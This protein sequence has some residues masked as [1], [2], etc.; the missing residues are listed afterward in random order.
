MGVE[1]T[2]K[3]RKITPLELQ[4]KVKEG[5]LWIIY[6][7][8]IIDVT[9]WSLYHPGGLLPLK[10]AA[11]LDATAQIRVFHPDY[12]LDKKLGSFIIGELSVDGGDELV[13]DSGIVDPKFISQAQRQII[14]SKYMSLQDEIEKEGLEITN[15]IFYF[16]IYFRLIFMFLTVWTLILY[17]SEKYWFV[18]S[19]LLAAF[20]HQAAFIGHDTGH[21]AVTHDLATDHNIGIT[22]ANFFGG[23]SLGWWKDSHYVHHVITN[24]P[25]HDPDIQHLPF[26]AVSEKFFSNL[27]SSY[28]DRIMKFDEFAKYFISLQHY[29]YYVVLCFGRFNL[30]AQSL[31]YLC[32]K[33]NIRNKWLEVV[34]LCFFWSWY[35]YLMSYMP[36]VL[37]G[38]L[39]T[40][41][42]NAMTVFLHIQITLSHFA[43]STEEVKENEEFMA[44]QL[45]TTMD[46]DS[47]RYM[48]WFHG[49]LQFQAIHHLFPRVPRH[50]LRLVRTK[51]IKACKEIDLPYVCFGF[52]EANFVVIRSLR[53][54]AEAT[55]SSLLL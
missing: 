33:A 2:K 48:D 12:V 43:M 26:F 31:I 14:R 37:A 21:S 13:Q 9:K 44:H 45:R 10:H 1:E 16:K 55:A 39:F 3:L 17:D 19:L 4:E 35:A 51:V 30:Y 5:H 8:K 28:H 23:L 32:K 15:P 27:Y 49:G 47:P 36:T 25:H 20:W 40:F 24:D 41:I 29:L 42:S 53:K 7:G 54:V 38:F 46:I 6:D 11:G 52:V 18:A 50:N 34:G 22:I